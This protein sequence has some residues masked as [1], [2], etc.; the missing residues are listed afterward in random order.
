MNEPATKR[1]S[2]PAHGGLGYREP[3]SQLRVGGVISQSVSQLSRWVGSW[4][5]S[6]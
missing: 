2:R 5:V 6:Q 1:V 4:L 3:V